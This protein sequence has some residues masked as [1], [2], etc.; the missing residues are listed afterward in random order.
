[1]ESINKELMMEI[2]YLMRSFR[3]GKHSELRGQ[4]RA[5][6]YL[7]KQDGISQTDLLA[8]MDV[9]PSSLSEL[10]NKM[11]EKG[12]IERKEARED[13][14]I[15]LIYLSKE[16]RSIAESMSKSAKS[17][18]IFGELDEVEKELLLSLLKKLD[19]DRETYPT[20]KRRK[21]V[22]NWEEKDI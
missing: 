4:R 3:R 13:K 1:M 14:R 12:H 20:K 21:D 10:L 15:R 9:R 17:K 6:H 16:G 19:L 18:K 7:L 2:R 8:L 22:K 5:L 11:E